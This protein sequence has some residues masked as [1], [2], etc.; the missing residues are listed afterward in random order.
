MSY[1]Q[2]PTKQYQIVANYLVEKISA[3]TVELRS[4]LGALYPPARI[5]DLISRGFV[6]QK[7]RVPYTT[8]DGRK[9]RVVRYTL[10]KPP[11]AKIS[12]HLKTSQK[13][14]R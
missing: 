6:I 11:P 4:A 9:T 5:S 10:L 3:T 7:N 13:T 14:R 8:P 2:K 1:Y 12:P